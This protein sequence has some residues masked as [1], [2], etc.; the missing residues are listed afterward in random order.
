MRYI[1]QYFGMRK[2]LYI[3]FWGRVVTNMGALIWP[4]MTL[5]LKSK[6]GYSASQIA[7]IL[8]ILGI[9]QFPF[10]LIGGKLADR[11]NK[12]NLIIIC[13]MVTVISYFICAF[14]PVSEK[15]IPLLALAAIFAQMEW[16]S[17]DALVADLSSSEEREKAYSLN[18]LGGNLGL[19]L[20]PT[21]GGFLFANHL[22]LAFLINSF[23]TFSSTVLIFFFIKDITP[24]KTKEMTQKYEGT[25]DGDSVWKILWENKLLILFML[26][27]GIWTLV[28]RQLDFLIPLN[29]E[30]SYGEQ[31]A[32][33]FGTLTSVNALVVIVGT[34]ILTKI[35]E[36][37]RDVER[38]LIGQVLIILG[39]S[40]YALVQ[41]VLVIYFV[42][43]VVFT[44]GEI[45][46]TLGNQPY[47]TRRIP[48]SHRGRFSS[49]YTMVTGAF[50]LGGQKVVGSMVDVMSLQ[51]V[52]KYI[53]VIGILNVVGY[54]ILCRR[55]RKTFSLF[56]Q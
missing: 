54:L 28:Y 8:I 37:V 7:S 22:S 29:L 14:L 44:F 20:A 46:G 49:F 33:L 26:C 4:M 52:W 3:L 13:D 24:V 45:S 41:N 32:V 2:E 39:L 47:L 40:A 17:Y 6:L 55:D 36:C 31:G 9:A 38:L 43:M 12:R 51:T 15:W 21:I 27:G 48:A 1:R 35:M 23:A 10:T 30:Q 42:S 56:Y 34:P 11:Y 19:V 50:Q 18:Y 25:R 53:V 5:I 16:P